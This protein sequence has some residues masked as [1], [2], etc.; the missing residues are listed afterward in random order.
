MAFLDELLRNMHLP[1]V[2]SATSMTKFVK[3][4]KTDGYCL[5]DGP[6]LP[7]ALKRDRSL[8]GV[9]RGEVHNLHPV[10]VNSREDVGKIPF[11]PTS[12]I[13]GHSGDMLG[14][15][16]SVAGRVAALCNLYG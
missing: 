9:R 2:Q 1:N 5:K 3:Q 8:V 16:A 10:P 7:A 13:K 12:G 15:S 4:L 14:V 6:Q 11:I